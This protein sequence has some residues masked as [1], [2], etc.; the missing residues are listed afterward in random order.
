MTVK[1]LVSDKNRRLNFPAVS[2]SSKQ[3][4]LT[5]NQPAFSL[6]AKEYRVESQYVQILFDDE[7]NA[8]IFFIKLCDETSLGC[9]KLDSPSTRTRTCS[10]SNLIEVLNWS[11]AGTTRFEMTYDNQFEAGKVNTNKPLDFEER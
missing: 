9:R 7:D 4:K 6:L 2:I 1:V 5:L 8:G 3:R 11:H 10:I